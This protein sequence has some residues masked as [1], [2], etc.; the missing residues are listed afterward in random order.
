MQAAEDTSVIIPEMT[1][2]LQLRDRFTGT[3]SQD[4][5]F[6]AT[7]QSSTEQETP[8]TTLS[9]SSTSR[10]L[11]GMFDVQCSKTSPEFTRCYETVAPTLSD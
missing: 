9:N 10:N 3:S 11:P 8:Q 5:F 1:Q 2:Q 6:R 4:Q 7:S